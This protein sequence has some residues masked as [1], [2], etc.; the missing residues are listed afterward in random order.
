LPDLAEHLVEQPHV[1][2]GN[3]RPFA[4]SRLSDEYAKALED[5]ALAKEQ[6]IKT[7]PVTKGWETGAEKSPTT[8]RFASF[9]AFHLSPITLPLYFAIHETY[10]HLLQAI[11]QKPTARFIQCWYNIHRSGASLVRHCHAY[12]FI[13][14][15]S[16]YADGSLTQYGNA[17]E[18]SGEDVVIE[19]VPGQLVITTGPNHYHHT[20]TWNDPDRA[21]VTYAFDILGANQW[22]SNQIFLP[23]DI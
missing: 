15:F 10:R 11:D 18:L 17:K 19:H 16:A 14:T 13:G 4:F 12:P 3:N 9:S 22:N 23:F 5:L 8:A 2:W 7:L 1:E 20:S 21:R 6:L